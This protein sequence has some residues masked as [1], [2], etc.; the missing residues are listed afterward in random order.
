M[1]VFTLEFEQEISKTF[2]TRRICFLF[3]NQSYSDLS[4]FISLYLSTTLLHK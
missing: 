3:C 2:I 1:T 4:F